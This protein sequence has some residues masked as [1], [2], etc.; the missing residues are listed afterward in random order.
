MDAEGE[1]LHIPNGDALDVD[2]DQQVET[3]VLGA[4]LVA[5]SAPSSVPTG[6][7][8]FTG[9]TVQGVVAL[10]LMLVAIGS[11]ILW[12]RRRYELPAS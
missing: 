1:A 5:P 3:I 9:T 12:Q 2:A 8:A 7:L 6:P 4:V 11:T 10:A